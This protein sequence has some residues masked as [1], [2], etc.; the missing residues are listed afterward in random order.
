MNDFWKFLIIISLLLH[1]LV[2][3][4]FVDLNEVVGIVIVTA[5]AA[6]IVGGSCYLAVKAATR[7]RSF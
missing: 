6:T 1:G 2:I 7:N 3:W 4:Q 5:W